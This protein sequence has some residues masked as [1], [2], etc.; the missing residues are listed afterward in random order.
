MTRL[1]RSPS[2]RQWSS[3]G[4][5][6]TTIWPSCT[7]C[8]VKNAFW[9]RTRSYTSIVGTIDDEGIQKVWN[10]NVRTR[11]ASSTATRIVTAVSVSARRHRRR[12]RGTVPAGPS[13]AGPA[14]RGF[15]DD[16]LRAAR[17]GEHAG[18]GP[19]HA[20]PAVRLARDSRPGR[21]RRGQQPRRDTQGTGRDQQRAGR[22][23]QAAAWA[24]REP[25]ARCA[26]QVT[27]GNRA[28]RGPVP[29]EQRGQLGGLLPVTAPPA[30]RVAPQHGLDH[31]GRPG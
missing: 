29:D 16:H 19:W 20:R 23:A 13:S 5:L 1:T 26:G 28:H 27:P 9:T 15:P 7:S 17:D 2:P 30:G 24:R 3:G 10:T 18:N 6:N 31:P 11:P 22:R 25:L 8:Q 14:M 4:W 12:R 21:P